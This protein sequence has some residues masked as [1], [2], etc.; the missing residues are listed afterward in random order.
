[1]ADKFKEDIPRIQAYAPERWVLLRNY[2][3][4][5]LFEEV[6]PFSKLLQEKYPDGR[7]RS[8]DQDVVWATSP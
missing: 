2:Q 3:I 7:A 4:G 8:G 1:M 5:M 6:E